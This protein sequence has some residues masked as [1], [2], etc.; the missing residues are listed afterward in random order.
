M[1]VYRSTGPDHGGWAGLEDIPDGRNSPSSPDAG[2]IALKLPVQRGT[3]ARALDQRRDAR[4]PDREARGPGDGVSRNCGL[5]RYGGAADCERGAVAA[6]LHFAWLA[7][8]GEEPDSSRADEPRSEE[9][10]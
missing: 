9:H 1:S 3:P 4:Q 2:G 6:E 7:R 8:A 5:R 10:T